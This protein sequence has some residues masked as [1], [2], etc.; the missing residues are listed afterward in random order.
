MSSPNQANA[1][2]NAKKM[3]NYN[4]KAA[5]TKRAASNTFFTVD[6]MKVYHKK[7][8]KV[9]TLTNFDVAKQ[10]GWG[11]G[12]NA[13]KK[14]LYK[15]TLLK[16]CMESRFEDVKTL[17]TEHANEDFEGTI[18]NEE[19]LCHIING[20]TRDSNLTDVQ[21]DIVE[22][23]LQHVVTIH[24]RDSQAK[25]ELDTAITN[26][27]RPFGGFSQQM[28]KNFVS[29]WSYKTSALLAAFDKVLHIEDNQLPANVQRLIKILLLKMPDD[30][31]THNFFC[32][33][34][35]RF[36]NNNCHRY[37]EHLFQISSNQF[38][39]QIRYSHMYLHE[40][41]ATFRHLLQRY[42]FNYVKLFVARHK[43]IPIDI[44][45]KNTLDDDD[46]YRIIVIAKN[47]LLKMPHDS[48]QHV[49]SA[50]TYYY[51]HYTSTPFSSICKECRFEDLKLF[52]TN[53]K[54]I[55]INGKV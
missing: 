3:R 48:N 47:I 36:N 6:N 11:G 15:Q 20:K 9:T 39:F 26:T 7:S 30:E 16:A 50:I 25:N 24:P 32:S 19:H 5:G 35:H 54:D 2:S 46:L 17:I 29:K 38:G 44:A 52:L 27:R 40:K 10:H 34:I 18:L 43:E 55:K 33:L 45:F 22:Y 41:A 51:L 37:L 53:D 13:Y 4:S 31:N 12:D 42:R 8:R 28:N 49:K 21:V 14:N 23:L 1:S